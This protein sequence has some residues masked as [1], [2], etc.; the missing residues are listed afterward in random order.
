MWIFPL[1]NSSWR[2]R[3]AFEG[4]NKSDLNCRS[5]KEDG[6]SAEYAFEVSSEGELEQ[7]RPALVCALDSGKNVELVFASE[8]VEKQCIALSD[9]YSSNLRIYRYPLISYF[10]G[11]ASRDPLYWLTASKLYLCRYDFFPEVMRYGRKTAKEFVLLNASLKSYERKSSNSLY[12]FAYSR[13]YES[14]DKIVAATELDLERFKDKFGLNNE[15]ARAFDFR[16]IAI[17]Q[18]INRGDETLKEKFPAFEEFKKVISKY[19]K[20]NR[21]VFGSFWATEANALSP[22]IDFQKYFICFFP[23][24]LSEA[25]IKNTKEEISNRVNSPV[26]VLDGDATSNASILAEFDKKPGPIIVNLK[27]VLLESYSEFGC[28]FVGGGHGVSVH[29]LLEPFLSG[30]MVMCGPKV[31]RSTE[32]ELIMEKNPDRLRVV[33]R[34][35]NVFENF[36]ETQNNNPATLDAFKASYIVKGPEVMSWLGIFTKQG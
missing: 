8:S 9:K 14:F 36:K 22:E 5:F 2:K 11:Q 24:K 35:E 13:V 27:G 16:P 29:S 10:P 21:L 18:R 30:C 17:E 26:Y 33:D 31:H 20:E 19:P 15:N 23:H 3:L 12:K 7:I 25:D 1:A 34:L 32:Y 6:Q 4:Q 28:A